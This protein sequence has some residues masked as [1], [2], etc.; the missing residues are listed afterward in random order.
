MCIRDRLN[1]MILGMPVKLLITLALLIG[2]FPA[3][4]K[5]IQYAFEQLPGAFRN[6][7]KAFPIIFIF[8]SSGEKTEE[9]NGKK[10]QDARK[11]GQVAKS[12]DISLTFTLLA[13]TL[14]CV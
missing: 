1:V 14:R 4:L 3:T 8:S 13:A 10:L 6:L 2:M 9:A 5:L 7:Y 12:R 11:K